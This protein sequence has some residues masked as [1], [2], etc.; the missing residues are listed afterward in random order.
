METTVE[1]NRMD[2]PNIVSHAEWIAAR[3]EPLNEPAT[4][5]TPPARLR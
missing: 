4:L 3:T 5:L 1:Q 2:P